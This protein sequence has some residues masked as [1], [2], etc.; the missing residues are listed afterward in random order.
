MSGVHTR[1]VLVLMGII[2]TVFGLVYFATEFI[3]VIS[4]WGRVASFVLLAVV[5]VS[6]GMHFGQ[7]G[8]PTELVDRGGW[9]WLRVTNALYILGAVCAG[10]GVI[11]FFAVEGV[12]RLVKVLVTIGLGLGLILVAAR[13]V[14]RRPRDPAG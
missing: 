3:D 9:R 12:D 11:A 2:V 14:D 13:R 6:L 1:N 5:F 8:D 4:D 7:A 10:G